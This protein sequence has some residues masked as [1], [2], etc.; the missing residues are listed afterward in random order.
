MN[1]SL[2]IAKSGLDAQQTKMSNI[3]NNLANAGTTGFKSFIR[4]FDR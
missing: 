4:M 2:W 1:Q 3:A